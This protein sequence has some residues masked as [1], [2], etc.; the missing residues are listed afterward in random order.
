MVSPGPGGAPGGPR[1]GAPGGPRGDLE[2]GTYGELRDASGKVLRHVFITF[3]QRT[4]AAPKLPAHVPVGKLFTVGSVGS[5]GPQYRVYASRDVDTG[6]L[7]IAAVPTSEVQQTL[8][9]LLLVEALVIA[10]VLLALAIVASLVVRLGLRPLDRMEATAGKIAAG[11]LSRRVS[12][13]DAS[14]RGRPPRAGAERDA[15]SPR[16]GVPAARGQRVPPAAL[17]GRRLARAAHAAGLDP[18]LRRAVPDGRHRATPP[19]RRTRCAG[20]RRRPPAWGCWSRTCWRSPA[21]TEPPEYEH[22]LVDSRKL[23][24]DAVADARAV[25]PDRTITLDGRA[26]RMRR[27]A[28]RLQLRQ[29]LANLLRNALTHTPAASP[30]E[31]A[32]SEHGDAVDAVGA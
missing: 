8:H 30:V 17:P 15:R 4:P 22:E 6:G 16:A 18:R 1:G 3:G 31:V 25:A 26:R 10:A 27:R 32:V 9:H 11:D 14:H 28:T 21:S 20:S 29:V 7:T 23:A 13:A 24:A 12:P 2:P 5:S 19:R